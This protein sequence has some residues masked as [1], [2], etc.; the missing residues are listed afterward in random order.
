MG[1]NRF[2]I[3]KFDPSPWRSHRLC[4]LKGIASFL[5]SHRTNKPSTQSVTTE[6]KHKRGIVMG[7]YSDEDIK[8]MFPLNYDDLSSDEQ[9]HIIQ[10]I[11]LRTDT[12]V[13]RVL[14]VF[15]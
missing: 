4:V 10:E 3:E 11:A 12:S 1:Q 5:N 13:D 15:A 14:S 2:N 7:K 8:M 9:T 6:I